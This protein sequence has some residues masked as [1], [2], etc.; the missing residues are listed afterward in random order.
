MNSKVNKNI[1]YVCSS[2]GYISVSWIGRCPQCEEWNTLVIQ[3]TGNNMNH[4]VKIET[5]KQSLIVEEVRL[6]SG[7]K[8]IDQVFG[9]G[10]V[11]GSV[12]LISGEPGI[13]KS[14]LLLQIA[15]AVANN[16]NVL[17][18]SGEE[19]LHQVALRANRLNINNNNLKI[20]SSI[21]AN[22]IALDIAH[23]TN[24]LV[25]I[26]SI[27][28]LKCDEIGAMAG[29]ISQVTNSAAILN[30]AA[31]QSNTALIIVGHVT[32][33]G[34]LAGPKL[35]E[36]LVDVVLTLEGETNIGLKLLRVLKNRFG[37]TD[38][39]AIFEM[40]SQ[41]L[42]PV[43]N[44][45]AILLAERKITDGSVVFATMEGSRSV[46]VEIQSLVNTTSYGYPKR[47]VSGY[48]LGRMNLL[49]AMIEKRTSLKLGD[50]DVY[51]NVVGGLK[52]SEPAADLAVVMSICSAAR[53]KKLKDNAVIFGE[54]GLSGEIRHVPF[55]DKRVSEAKALGFDYAIGPKVKDTKLLSFVHV[56]EDVK[57]ALNNFLM[58]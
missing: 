15:N 58:N 51:L 27:Q 37:S 35:L 43:V 21:N 30:L 31:K 24:K 16:A 10:I 22:E 52:I 40:H 29:S 20:A 2:C 4:G 33:E 12:N 44:P 56:C 55:I 32:K 47:A 19:S 26:D 13:G 54:V 42:V 7:I 11:Q 34:G 57:S 18:V 48:D 38:E 49:I 3:S 14:T 25:I 39:T 5:I 23:G 17:Y 53:N 8:V 36:H 1:N 9:G 28:S 41:G 45:S 6:L 50:K 46:L